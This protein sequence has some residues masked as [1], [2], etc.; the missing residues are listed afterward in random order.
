MNG[1][2]HSQ[3]K[4]AKSRDKVFE[5]AYKYYDYVLWVA[6]NRV[7]NEQVAEDIAQTVFIK[8][9]LSTTFREGGSIR[10]YLAQICH[11]EC[12]TYLNSQKAKIVD[13]NESDSSSFIVNEHFSEGF[14]IRE[15]IN[16][17]IA[18]LPDRW[19]EAFSL[20]FYQNH[21][22][23]EGAQA[24]NISINT[25]KDIMKLT[26]KRVRKKLVHLRS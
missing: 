11:H 7:K 16:H 1:Q 15:F 25:F 10:N 23:Q 22:Y 6:K 8:F 18:D 20:V 9:W 5:V 21:S 17:V 14:Q 19:R 13:L 4:S 12:L 24:M 26:L 3:S 2:P